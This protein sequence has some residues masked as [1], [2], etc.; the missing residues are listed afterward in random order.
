MLVRRIEQ[1]WKSIVDGRRSPQCLMFHSVGKSDELAPVRPRDAVSESVFRSVI[2][3]LAAGWRPTSVPDL[4]HGLQRGSVAERT[5]A[6]TF[7]DGF[8]D[9]LTTALPILEEFNVPA[10]VYVATG[11]IERTVRPFQYDLASLICQS[12]TVRFEWNGIKQTWHLDGASQRE[13]C[14][15]SI[16]RMLKPASAKCRTAAMS[17]LTSQ[18][19]DPPDHAERYLCWERLRELAAS[20]LITIGGHTHQHLV[21]DAV[22]HNEMRTDI[23]KGK[24]LLEKQLG[25]P[26]THFSFPYGHHNRVVRNTVRELGF[27]S[28]MSIGIQRPWQRKDPFNIK[29]TPISSESFLTVRKAA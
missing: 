6:V 25:E 3:E 17:E 16:Y 10:T 11:F 15:S 8:A 19:E 18:C 5:A 28:A 4:V 21:L 27:E 29:R 24:Q 13:S 20:P 9:N 23:A 14:Y 1:T 26:I 7:D 22:D 2:S 12:E